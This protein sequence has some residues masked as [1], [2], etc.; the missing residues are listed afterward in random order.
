MKLV[1]FV[2]AMI[3]AVVLSACTANQAAQEAAAEAKAMEA[4]AIEQAAMKA[5]AQATEMAKNID[6][7]AQIT[8]EKLKTTNKSVAYRCQSGKTVTATYAFEGNDARAVN[9][10]LGT[11]KKALKASLL[12][13]DNNKDFVS[14]TSDQYVWNVDSALTLDTAAKTDAVHLVKKGA[15]NDEILAKLCDVNKSATKRLNK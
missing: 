5:E 12:R 2:P 11:G 6:G 10:R 15:Q 7:K 13:D 8:V 14:F 3:A 4:Q 9:V 1:K